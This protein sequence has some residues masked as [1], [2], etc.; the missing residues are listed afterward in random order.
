MDIAALHEHS[1]YVGLR[2]VSRVRICVLCRDDLAG[3][4]HGNQRALFAAI[5]WISRRIDG[6]SKGA[7]KR[8]PLCPAHIRLTA[9][10]SAAAPLAIE[11]P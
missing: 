5:R 4:L 2:H 3:L 7:G 11:V 6:P 8:P 1:T 9:P 10:G